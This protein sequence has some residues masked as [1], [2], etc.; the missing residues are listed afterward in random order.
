MASTTSPRV[1][2]YGGRGGLGTVLVSHF[3]SKG[4][5]VCS[6]DLRENEEANENVIVNPDDDWRAQETFVAAEVAKRLPGALK[7]DAILNMAGGWAGGAA[8]S[9][10]F[11]KNAD[12]MWKQSV[13]SSAISAAVASKHLKEDGCIVLPGA[14]P[15]LAGTPGMEQSLLVFQSC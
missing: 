8:D 6:V 7:V 5:W 4:W 9:A 10:D 15:A 11:V 12:L 1:L 2:I 3:K 13:W 14:K